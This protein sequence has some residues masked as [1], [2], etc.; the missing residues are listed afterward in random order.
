MNLLCHM[1]GHRGSGRETYNGGYFF[2]RCGRCNG[3]LIRDGREWKPV[4][5]GHR[6]VWKA[7]RHSHAMAPDYAHALP[8]VAASGEAAARR[9]A[10][11]RAR[12]GVLVPV[13]P[14]RV[15]ATAFDDEQ[16]PALPGF[17]LLL[18]TAAGAAGALRLL[19]RRGRRVRSAI[20][21]RASGKL[22][23]RNAGG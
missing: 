23:R 10:A 8:V 19:S 11:R 9:P 20:P 21:W 13:R 17:L 5:P 16:E 3:D 14:P 15:S 22:R 18:V 12:K 7:G 2:A 1:V 4:P 6:V